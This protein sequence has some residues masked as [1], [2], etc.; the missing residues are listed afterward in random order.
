MDDTPNPVD[1]KTLKFLRVLVTVLTGTMIVGVL[2][3]I[4]LLV[5]RIAAPAPMV[6]AT[7][8]LPNGTVPTAYTQTA[9]WVAVVSDDN[10]ILIF[11]RLT[12]ALIQEID[13]KTAP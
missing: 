1:E 6:P 11:N 5:T 7:L 13:V 10:R 2:V 9:D 12:G 4:G 8:T 3:I